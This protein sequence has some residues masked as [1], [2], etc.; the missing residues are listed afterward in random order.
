MCGGPRPVATARCVEVEISQ[1]SPTRIELELGSFTLLAQAGMSK[2]SV[3][4]ATRAPPLRGG[5]SHVDRL[6]EPGARLG[7]VA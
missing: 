1:S 3:L 5:A 6:R 2:T 4:P 7:R